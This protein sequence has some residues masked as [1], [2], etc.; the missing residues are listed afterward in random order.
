MMKAVVVDV[1]AVRFCKLD[2]YILGFGQ[3]HFAI[4]KNIFDGSVGG[5]AAD[6]EGGGGGCDGG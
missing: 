4:W 2:K 3:I 1:M 5:D 6:D